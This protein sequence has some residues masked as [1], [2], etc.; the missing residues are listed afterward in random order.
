MFMIRNVTGN[1]M[2]EMLFPAFR[3][4][5]FNGATAIRT[6]SHRLRQCWITKPLSDFSAL[7]V[8]NSD[9]AI[10]EQMRWLQSHTDDEVKALANPDKDDVHTHFRNRI[11]H[12]Y[13]HIFWDVSGFL[14][15]AAAGTGQHHPP[16]HTVL[17]LFYPGSGTEAAH[18]LAELAEK[19]AGVPW[20]VIP[21]YIEPGVK[22]CISSAGWQMDVLES[23][24]EAA[25]EEKKM[26]E[27]N[28]GIVFDATEVKGMYDA[29]DIGWVKAGHDVD[30]TLGGETDRTGVAAVL[31]IGPMTPCEPTA[32]QQS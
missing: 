13:N 7:P 12:F 17:P 11:Y 14:S 19:I 8:E 20:M 9:A 10:G 2:E 16:N 6:V 30:I 4:V 27:Q 31:V 24:E 15:E 1:T 29:Y 26:V 3:K 28:E 23:R 5:D 22:V 18:G 25:T 32:T 21:A